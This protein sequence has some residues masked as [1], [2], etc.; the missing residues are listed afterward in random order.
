MTSAQNP[1]ELFS[2]CVA[3]QE[4]IKKARID[5]LKLTLAKESSFQPLFEDAED[6][7]PNIKSAY[8]TSERIEQA[9]WR[10]NKYRDLVRLLRNAP[11]RDE[12][13]MVLARWL[14]QEKVCEP[15]DL[16]PTGF[17]SRLAKQVW[18]GT[19]QD[20]VSRAALVDIWLP[21][22]QRLIDEATRLEKDGVHRKA[23]VLKDKGYD[24]TA[25]DLTSSEHSPFEAVYLWLED[26]GHGSA[27]TF[28][29][30]CARFGAHLRMLAPEDIVKIFGRELEE[31]PKQGRSSGLL[32]R[33]QSAPQRRTRP[34]RRNP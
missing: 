12:R 2:A 1:R 26:R 3:R 14:R 29:N 33:A 24:E 17:L 21:Y 15:E 25:V 16:L 13:W 5:Q 7:R 32:A 31:L 18:K 11:G 34:P 28:R 9:I 19:R 27:E 10:G 4:E 23:E 8:P 22:F 20:D 30:V 6:I